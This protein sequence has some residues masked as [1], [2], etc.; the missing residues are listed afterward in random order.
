MTTATPARPRGKQSADSTRGIVLLF[1][2]LM[3]SM[4]LASLSQTVLST[5]LPTVVG[6]LNGVDHML[7]VMT[8]FILASTIMMP[9]YGKLGDLIGRKGLMLAAIS[10]FVAGSVVGAL[11]ADMNWL[12]VG[13]V[14]QGL[15]GG[16]LMILSQAIIADV[17]PARERGKYMGIMGAVFAVS[18][19]AGPLLGGWFTEGI[20]WRWTFWINVPL[21]VLALLATI[22][23]LHLPKGTTSR[24]K[25]DVAGMITLAVTTTAFIL[26]AS[27]GGKDFQWTSPTILGLIV[28]TL[29]AAG[30][31]VIIERRS[32]EP[33][34]PLHLFRKRNFNLTTAAGLLT[35]IA[36]FG[37]IGYLP[38]YLQ[39]AFGVDA[40]Q[41]GLLMIPMMAGLLITSVVAGVVVSRTGRYKWMPIVGSL[42]VALGLFLLSTLRTDTPLWMLCVYIAVLGIGLGTSMQILV[43]I[44][45][46]TFPVREVG[47]ATASNNYFRQIGASLGSAVVG[48]LF[49]T[50][51]T[52]ILSERLPAT[53][54]TGES[55]SNSLTPASVAAMPEEIRSIITTA[56]NE[57]LTPLFLYMVPL[58]LL[59][60]VLLLFVR[61]EP[62]A[63]SIQRDVPAEALGEGNL[64][65]S[66]TDAPAASPAGDRSL[67]RS[68]RSG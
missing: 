68:G 9:V 1:V 7:W 5:A 55:P 53:P 25:I 49:T 32:A 36:M 37:A 19:V 52:S 50:R 28:L 10:L 18:S 43:L 29:V 34:I 56:Y 31:F 38:T 26:I 42:V 6:E 23:F 47:T 17:V 57:A 4:L 66:S 54:G 24:P 21:G 33:I 15:G 59:A 30:A 35:G 61:E 11:A 63:T 16:G 41:A 27:W 64:T 58:A 62:L 45:Q 46:N 14:I 12:I 2:G 3:L 44:V 51:L 8:A 48:S 39:M 67:A 13:R 60:F 40:T 20:G 65:I 22:F